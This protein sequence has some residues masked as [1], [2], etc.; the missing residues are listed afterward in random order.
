MSARFFFPEPLP[1][2]GGTLPLPEA[3]AHHA[4]RVLRLADGAAVTLFD[5]AGGECPA[6]LAHLGGKAWQAVVQPRVARERELPFRLAIVQALAAADKM[7][8]VIRK[9]TELGA[10]AFVPIAA[11][12]SVLRLAGE[13]RDKRLAHWQQVAQSACEQ[14]GR[15]RVPPVAPA[16]TLPE[17]LVT[18]PADARL[19][20]CDPAHAAA[21]SAQPAPTPQETIYLLIGPEGGWTD[22]ELAACRRAGAQPIHLGARVLRTE[23]AALAALAAAAALWGDS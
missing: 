8:W 16:C 7:D 2:H 23:T 21:L 6:T 13:R 15:N 1:D 5:G 3:L 12:R 17:F 4:T 14:C 18:L 11:Q 9:C 19:W 20:L 10:A 22:D